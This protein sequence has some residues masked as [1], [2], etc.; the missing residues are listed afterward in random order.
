MVET[1]GMP[2]DL[3]LISGNCHHNI[4]LRY[5]GSGPP[6]V[7]Y[8]EADSGQV[9]EVAKSFDAFLEILQPNDS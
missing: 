4:A 5:R 8:Y 3:L 1:W 2:K 9:L 6:T 7:V